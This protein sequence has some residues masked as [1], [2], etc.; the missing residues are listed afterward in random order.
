MRVFYLGFPGPMGGANT[1]MLHTIPVWRRAGIDV[2][3]VPTWGN[4]GGPMAEKMLKLGCEIAQGYTAAT[5]A[6]VPGIAGAIVH[7][8]CNCHFWSVFGALKRLGCKTVWSSCMTFEFPESQAG[9][10]QHGPADAYHFQSAFQRDEMTKL[11]A[12]L[13]FKP[14]GFLIRGAFDF[15]D[16]SFAPRA[17]EPKTDFVIGRLSRP[18]QDK[19]SSNLWPILNSVPYP[20]RK[21]LA[22]GWTAAA[23]G[24]C[25][26]PPGWAEAL[27]PQQ[28][29]V[30]A[31]L[32]RCHAMIGL[33][34]GARENWPRIGL[35]AMAAGVPLVVQNLWGWRE[36]IRHG[37]TGFL[38][39][40]DQ[41]FAFYLALLARDEGLRLRIADNARSAVEQLADPAVIGRQWQQLFESLEAGQVREAA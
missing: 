38:C 11:H 8:M 19:W 22:M 13:G 15:S 31:F 14:N 25:G 39:D 37:E 32:N 24:K 7:S 34:G 3:L 5:I 16:F 40:N 29:P 9:V 10:R 18:E 12:T 20:E 33:N 6:N 1:E 2:T 30:P 4:A 21:A 35:E 27:S 23:E 36:M 41:D 26:R 17:H 28:I